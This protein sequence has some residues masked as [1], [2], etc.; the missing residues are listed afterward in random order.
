LADLEGDP[1]GVIYQQAQGASSGLLDGEQLDIGHLIGDLFLDLCHLGLHFHH[2]RVK[3][4]KKR[5]EPASRQ[6]GMEKQYRV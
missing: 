5:A 3:P 6:R 4:Q 2:L 1:V